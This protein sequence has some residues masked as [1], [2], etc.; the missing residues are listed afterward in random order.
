M[1]YAD[2]DIREY[3]EDAASDKPA[4]G[5]GSIS[6]LTGALASSMSEMAANFTVGK[7]RY[8]DVEDRVRNCLRRLELSRGKLLTLME[9]DVEAY[10]AVNEAYDM[11]RGTDEEKNHRRE[12]IQEALKEAMMVPFNVMQ[13][14]ANVAEASA[15]LVDIA[16]RNLLTD[17]GVSAIL[18]EAA[19]SAARLNVDIN[20]KYLKDQSLIDDVVPK[21]DKFLET[22]RDCRKKVDGKMQEY[23]WT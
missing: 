8:A 10:T 23:L 1:A 4:P 14:C 20:I 19:C 13:Q 17:V 6:A 18:A 5:G 9:S 7:D 15:E 2:S 22:T 11:P 21:A 12:T 3:L 16:N